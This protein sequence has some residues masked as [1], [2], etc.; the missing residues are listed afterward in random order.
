MTTGEISADQNSHSGPERIH[1]PKLLLV[2]GREDQKVF[3]ELCAHWSI[4]GIQIVQ[5]EGI[6][7][8]KARLEVLV[9]DP[10]FRNLRTLAIARDAD[11]NAQNAFQSVRDALSK[12]PPLQK[13][14]PSKSGVRGE[15]RPAITVFVAPDNTSPGNL[16]TML[17]KTKAGDSIAACIDEF[18]GC[19]GRETDVKLSGRHQDKARAYARIAASSNPARS[20]GHSVQASGVWDLNHESLAPVKAFLSEL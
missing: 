11:N 10:S 1:K 20:I 14:L 7:N 2:E 3:K 9:R 18:F 16:E 19:L 8:L 12:C 6:K 17:N 15:G 13:S 4:E 5:M